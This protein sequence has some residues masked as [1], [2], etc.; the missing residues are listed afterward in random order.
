M[1]I[2][3]MSYND[4]QLRITLPRCVAIATRWPKM[5]NHFSFLKSALH[6][7]MHTYSN[8]KLKDIYT[9]HA[10]VHIYKN[11][12]IRAC[13]RTMSTCMQTHTLSYTSSRALTYTHA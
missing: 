7:R 5:A 12:C 13:E 11:I 8:M 2:N 3:Y 10:Y 9:P 6:T 4:S 1:R